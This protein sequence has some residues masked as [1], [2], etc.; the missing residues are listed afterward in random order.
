MYNIGF[1]L[2]EM[3][4]YAEAIETLKQVIGLHPNHK[5]AL[6]YL[7]LCFAERGEETEAHKYFDAALA[8]DPLYEY[9]QSNKVKLR[10]GAWK[11]RRL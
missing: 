7:G 4:C 6:N 9:A 8:V 11:R 3:G 10:Q 5:S 1:Q 2:Y